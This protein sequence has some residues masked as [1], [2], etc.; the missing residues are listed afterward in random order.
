[1]K[2]K[3]VTGLFVVGALVGLYILY[4]HVASLHAEVVRAKEI[5]WSTRFSDPQ[6]LAS[7]FD[8]QQGPGFTLDDTVGALAIHRAK[9]AA[10]AGGVVELRSH[11]FRFDGGTARVRFKVSGLAPYD[12]FMGI[13]SAD[14]PDKRI[15]LVL[16]NDATK[17]TFRL[18]GIDSL[19]GPDPEGDPLL[20]Y[21]EGEKLAWGDGTEHTLGLRFEPTSQTIE[22]TIDDVPVASRLVGWSGGFSG[23][24]V[25]GVRDRQDAAI[26]AT[27]EEVDWIPNDGRELIRGTDFTDTFLGSHINPLRWQVFF[28]Q[29]WR[30][31][32]Q[33][34][35]LSTGD[36]L[37]LVGQSLSQSAPEITTPVEVCTMPFALTPLKIETQ[38][39]L[40]QLDLASVFVSIRNEIKTRSIEMELA[41][42]DG[43]GTIAL[44]VK[45]QLDGK[46]DV[47]VSHGPTFPA[48]GA[49]LNITYD[50]WL[51]SLKVSNDEVKVF[52]HSYG[53]RREELVRVCLGTHVFPG[54]HAEAVLKQVYLH[55][56]PY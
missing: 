54:G 17:P 10:P 21:I 25:F 44:R 42:D 28:Q 15:W 43:K 18:E 40:R 53:L 20:Q 13:E 27:F 34:P 23:R 50:P 35:P 45:G 56:A 8:I 2:K 6:A 11:P 30:T 46:R 4:A 24:L 29:E 47:D 51:R 14:R 39:D 33:L 16:R 37:L 19:R 26:D 49:H 32:G 9:G 55:R 3:I 48:V 12:L 41:N 5:P 38:W 1:V 36:G 22:M 7:R 52:D 31:D